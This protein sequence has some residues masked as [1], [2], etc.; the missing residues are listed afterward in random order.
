MIHGYE[1]SLPFFM[2]I[3]AVLMVG[4]VVFMVRSVP[5]EKWREPGHWFK[6]FIL[7]NFAGVGV[8]L[9]AFGISAVL[10]GYLGSAL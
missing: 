2:Q 8:A 6:A 10:G 7:F 1:I 5:A 4:V 3:F 9:V